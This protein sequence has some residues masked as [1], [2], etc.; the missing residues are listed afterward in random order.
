[1]VSHCLSLLDSGLFHHEQPIHDPN[2]IYMKRYWTETSF[3]WCKNRIYLTQTDPKY[4]KMGNIHYLSVQ[5]SSLFSQVAL[6]TWQKVALI[7][8]F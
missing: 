5:I 6:I 7:L 2:P 8:K 3:L 4:I 1:M